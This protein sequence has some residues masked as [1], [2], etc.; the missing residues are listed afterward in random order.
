VNATAFA[1]TIPAT[2]ISSSAALPARSP[3]AVDGA[4][5]LTGPGFDRGERVGHGEP[6]V[7]VANA[8]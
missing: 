3:N 8:R 2:T 1:R 4:F 7:V 5:D 6:E